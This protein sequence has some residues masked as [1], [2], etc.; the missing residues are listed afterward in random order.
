M[1]HHHRHNVR[2]LNFERI[3]TIIDSVCNQDTLR[4]QKEQD[5]SARM[6]LLQL[7]KKLQ[8]DGSDLALLES[9]TA[10]TKRIKILVS[11]ICHV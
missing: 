5:Y 10:H 8:C 2:D 6:Q 11:R 1:S 4:A 3:I 9:T 7:R